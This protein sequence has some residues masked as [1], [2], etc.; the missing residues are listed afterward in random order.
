MNASLAK[1]Y[2]GEKGAEG[3][4]NHTGPRSPVIRSGRW[5]MPKRPQSV[6]GSMSLWCSAEV[7]GDERK[8][9]DL[10]MRIRAL[11]RSR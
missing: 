2:C 8:R 11:D 5:I 6:F 10:C 1:P 9:T 7:A 4:N 3:Q